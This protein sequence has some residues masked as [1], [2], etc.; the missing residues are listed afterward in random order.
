MPGRGLSNP[1]VIVWD[2]PDTARKASVARSIEIDEIIA[3]IEVGRTRSRRWGLSG[4][5]AIRSDLDFKKG[6]DYK[7]VELGACSPDER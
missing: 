4:F 2:K 1:K 3:G 5:E 6:M 7:E